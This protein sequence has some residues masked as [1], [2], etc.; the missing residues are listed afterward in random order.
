MFAAPASWRHVISRSGDSCS[1][2]S[3][4]QVAL[5]GHAEEGVDA[6]DGE[7]VDEQL[8]PPLRLTGAARGR[9]APAGASA[10]PRPP[11]RR[12]RSSASRP[13]RPAGRGRGR[14]PSPRVSEAAAKTGSGPVSYHH[15][16]GPYSCDSPCVSIRILPFSR[17]RKPGPGC[18]C[19]YA[20]PPGG[21]ST[22]S[23]RSSQSAFGPLGQL[24][25]ERVPVD[26]G[27]AVVSLVPLDVV[28]H[29]VAGLG[30]DA[31]RMLG[32]A[33]HQWKYWPPSITIVCPVTKSDCGP[34]R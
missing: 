23:Q 31:V 28:D 9:S 11:D 25:H 16:S 5:A 7:L 3:T 2:S 1:A 22:R 10:S 21:K 33:Q 17:T 30:R 12:T 19:R 20:T 26:V 34:A 27:G 8:C 32:Q 4:S 6:V 13:T 15:S 18:V 14:T 24:P 29:A